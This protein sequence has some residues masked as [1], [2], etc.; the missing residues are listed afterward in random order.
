MEINRQ[1]LKTEQEIFDYVCQ[2]LAKQGRSAVDQGGLCR[3]RMEDGRMCAVGCLLTDEEAE[4][5]GEG[6]GVS[7]ALLP[8]RLEPHR[9][10]LKKLQEAHDVFDS[11]LGLC[12]KLSLIAQEHYLSPSAIELI[13]EWNGSNG[14]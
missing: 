6:A 12:T 10:F 11:K 5:T 1:D 8:A 3:Y 2:H 7:K 13:K 9:K 4:R 14:G